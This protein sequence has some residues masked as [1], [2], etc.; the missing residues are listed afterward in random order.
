MRIANAIHQS[1]AKAKMSRSTPWYNSQLDII[2]HC[3]NLSKLNELIEARRGAHKNKEE[4]DYFVINGRLVLD[5]CGQ[6][7]LIKDIV[8][9]D[10]K[11][12]DLDLHEI[13]LLTALT[14][15]EFIEMLPAGA[16]W[17]TSKDTGIPMPDSECGCCHGK[18]AITDYLDSVMLSDSETVSLQDF[19]GFTIAQIEQAFWLR[20]DATYRLVHDC[21]IRNDKWINTDPHKEYKDRMKNP[22]GY[23]TFNKKEDRPYYPIIDRDTYTIQPGDKAVF[24]VYRYYHPRCHQNTVNS[25]IRHELMMSTAKSGLM[26]LDVAEIENECGSESYRGKWLSITTE[27]GHLVVGWRRR[28]IEINYSSICNDDLFPD[29]VSVHS[30]GMLHVGNYNELQDALKKLKAALLPDTV[31]PFTGHIPCL[32]PQ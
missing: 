7:L 16:T 31:S 5:N 3:H 20:T 18:W 6:V 13:S 24:A 12:V 11:P 14:K 29:A 19:E 4:L 26:V 21:A 25:R 22:M 10:R 1:L 23:S 30:P 32:S 15:D 28:F 17:I 9:K 27:L 8:D 2:K